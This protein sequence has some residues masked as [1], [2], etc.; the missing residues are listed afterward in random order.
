MAFP[1]SVSG[2]VPA[3]ILD[4]SREPTEQ[5]LDRIETAMAA[6]RLRR[7]ERVPPRLTFHAKWLN[8]ASNDPL[9]AVSSGV[10]TVH[11]EGGR[12]Y[13]TYELSFRRTLPIFCVLLALCGIPPSVRASLA[14]SFG[15]IAVV[16][17]VLVYATSHAYGRNRAFRRFLTEVAT[18]IA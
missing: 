17:A 12:L 15:W 9:F 16:L 14:V 4:P 8:L 11:D 18:G 3:G 7:I 13:V 10:V 2:S 5:L 1:F 6:Y